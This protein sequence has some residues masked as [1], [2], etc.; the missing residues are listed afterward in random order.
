MNYCFNWLII[1]AYRRGLIDRE[2][3]VSL[4]KGVRFLSE[5]RGG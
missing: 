1:H 5:E 3:F 2:K 4:W